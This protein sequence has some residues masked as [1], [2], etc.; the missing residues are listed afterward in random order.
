MRLPLAAVSVF[1]KGSISGLEKLQL[2]RH[3]QSVLRPARAQSDEAFARDE[4][5]ARDH[6]LQAVEVGQPVRI[7]L[8]G[9]GER[10]AAAPGLEVRRLRS[11]RRAL[12]RRR[13][14]WRRRLRRRW[15]HSRWSPPSSR[16]RA[17]SRGPPEAT[18]ALMFSS[19]WVPPPE[20]TF[21]HGA[22][23]TGANGMWGAAGR[24]A[25][26]AV[27]EAHGSEPLRRR[28]RGHAGRSDAPRPRRS[29]DPAPRWPDRSRRRCGSPRSCRR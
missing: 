20:P 9:P 22:F 23:E 19:G 7:G 24:P 27:E 18:S 12:S 10:R 3:Q 17:R 25:A 14:G 8:V 6:G 4:H 29:R 13:R 5:L 28:P 11:A 1:S 26:E 15:R 2:Q 21:R 16:D